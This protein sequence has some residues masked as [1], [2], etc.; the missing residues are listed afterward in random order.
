MSQYQGKGEPKGQ[1]GIGV[2]QCQVEDLNKIQ[3]VGGSGS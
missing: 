2:G 1:S 3:Y